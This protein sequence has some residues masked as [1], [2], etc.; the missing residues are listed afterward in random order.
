[1]TTKP[2]PASTYVA[3][4]AATIVVPVTIFRV[5]FGA[6]PPLWVC[7]ACGVAGAVGCAI[8]TAAARRG[9]RG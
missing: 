2:I 1:M 4:I 6:F 3:L 7:V 8:G 5:A 9:A